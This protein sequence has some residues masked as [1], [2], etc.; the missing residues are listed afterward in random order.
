MGEFDVVI[1]GG[2]IA[3]GFLA[4][5]LVLAAPETRIL[6]LEASPTIEDLKVG[7]STV[8]LAT[9]YM[10]RR[11]RLSGYLYREQLPKNGLRFFFDS[12]EKDVPLTEMSEIG[13]DHFPFHPSFQLERAKLE[14]DLVTMNREAGVTVQ[15]GAKVVDVELCAKSGHQIA[16]EQSGARKTVEARWVVD[17]AGRRHLLCR[18]MGQKV[19]KE[20][21]LNTGGA[22]ARYRGVRD[23]DAVPDDAF[24]ARV[25]HTSRTL[26]TNH[27]MYEGY[28]I[29]FIPLAGN[30][31]SVGVVYDKDV[32][33]AA[34]RTADALD[35]FLREHRAVAELLDGAELHDFGAYAHLAYYTDQFFSSERWALTGEAGAFVDPFYSPGSDFIA[36]ANELI[37]DLILRDLSGE[38]AQ[39]ASR[40]DLYN[41]FYKLKY[42][43]ALRLY[44][45]QYATWGCYQVFRLKFLLDFHNYYNLIV[46]PY[47]SGRILDEEWLESEV[48]SGTRTLQ[49]LDAMADQ[50]ADLASFFRDRG[51]YHSDSRGRW[52]NGLNGVAQLE[53]LLGA[54]IDDELRKAEVD[55]AFGSVFAAIREVLDDAPG[56]SR[57]ECVLRE[58]S[59]PVICVLAN[60]GDRALERLMV[61]VGARLR[62]DLSAEFPEH[63]I[64]RVEVR[65]HAPD[66]AAVEVASAE[67]VAVDDPD[68]LARARE[69]WAMEAPSLVHQNL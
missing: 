65:P 9:H 50:F 18:K 53:P 46:W 63:D 4:R 16:Y 28:W 23:L 3:G 40:A 59:F 58:L 69:L 14:R 45:N 57:R 5:Q 22:W 52:A 36:V 27:F 34:P 15:L 43:S 17:A 10:V 47:M 64:G 66:S 32:V 60:Q 48:R 21:R 35:K 26:S 61:R 51:R 20:D 62:R 56:L 67:G 24:Q 44:R 1:I 49:L 55:R 6:V 31:T 30:L 25:R 7:E 19:H 8:E 2:G 11:L 12:P 68:V 37:G 33:D 39:W 29:W 42:E 13:S 41:R 38:D 54:T